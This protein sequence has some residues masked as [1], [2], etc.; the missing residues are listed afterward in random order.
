VA[1]LES[2]VVNGELIETLR[3]LDGGL[4]MLPIGTCPQVGVTGL[5]LGGGVGDNTRWAGLTSDHLIATRAVSAAGEYLEI[6]EGNNADL[7]WACQ[8]GGGGNFALHVDLTVQLI[9]APPRVSYFAME[10]AGADATKRAYGVLD[11]I[12][13]TAAEEFSAFAF[14]RASPRAGQADGTPRELDPDL[15]PNMEIVGCFIGK[16]ADLVD[17]VAPLLALKPAARVFASASYWDAQRWLAVTPGL[18]HGWADVNRYMKRALTEHEISG[19]VDLLLRAPVARPDRY[20]EFGLFGWAG[21]V[22]RNKSPSETAYFHRDASTMLRAGAQW[23]LGAPLFDQLALND[24]LDEAW[25]FLGRAAPRASY[26]NW[27]NERIKDWPSS[28]YGE[29]LARLVTVKKRYDPDN[30]FRSAQSV[31]LAL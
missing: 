1:R 20:V 28:Y 24:W 4:W 7:F 2:G 17:I 31:P 10:F 3:G 21:G 19:M 18:R 25:A 8:G 14:V 9:E 13:Q 11:G 30:V 16:E 12:L 15:F 23:N 22:V 6:D 27:P 26:L 29:N 5:V